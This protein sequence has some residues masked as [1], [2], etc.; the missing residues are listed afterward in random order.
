MMPQKTNF[1]V[2][3]VILLAAAALLTSTAE[4]AEVRQPPLD[5]Q[6]FAV[7]R[8]DATKINLDA[9][10]NRIAQTVAESDESAAIEQA[11]TALGP[12]TALAKTHLTA[13]LQAGGRD[14]FAVFG[15]H[16]FPRFYGAVPA[17]EGA[18]E[19]AD[20]IKAALVAFQIDGVTTDRGA[21]FILVG[22]EQT[23]ARLKTR[24][25]VRSASL[26]AA[27]QS[28]G[29][30]AVQVLFLPTPDQRRVLAEMLPALPSEYGL[31]GAHV[32]LQGLEW[33]ALG[34]DGPPNL[35]LN[36]TL[37]AGGTDDAAEL[38]ALL[39][40]AY[41]LLGQQPQNRAA[42][43]NLDALLEALTPRRQGA[44]LH[45][46]L[47]QATTDALVNEVV[48]PYLL[49]S[50]ELATRFPCARTLKGIGVA[51][52]VHANDHK[53][54]LPPNLDTLID[55]AQLPRRG[56]TCP[57]V[58]TRG[59][60]VYR[61]AGL[62][63]KDPAQLIVAFDKSENHRGNGRN[64]LFLDGH[65]DWVWADRFKEV[66]EADNKIRR[67]ARLPE[68]YVETLPVP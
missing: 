41:A 53:D 13:F 64:V 52:L 27:M 10:V 38:L 3:D 55:T 23:I 26:A 21:G 22:S 29:D 25:S 28:C 15:L 12:F 19:L 1:G 2:C 31:Q 11:K 34:L 48:T 61:G 60:F 65:V 58:K 57:A 59:S 37:Q 18:E 14:L 6:T 20:R 51:C 17:D 50:R 39:R 63:S 45:L 56:L 33:L 43:P 62:S 8:L 30:T 35:S 67:K 16:E 7:I 32:L 5:D 46:A 40:A 54:Q 68:H 42:V 36:L 47:D 49:R 24:S 9:W 44:R 4:S 66:I